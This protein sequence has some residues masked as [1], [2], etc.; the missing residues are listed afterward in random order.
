MSGAAASSSGRLPGECGHSRSISPLFIVRLTITAICSLYWNCLPSPSHR[1]TDHPEHSACHCI[2][3]TPSPLH[4][5]A[6][7]CRPPRCQPF[8][9]LL[10]WDTPDYSRSDDTWSINISLRHLSQA[11]LPTCLWCRHPGHL[12]QN[13]SLTTTL[14]GK[15]TKIFHLLKE[16]S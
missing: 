3:Q 11:L 8:P 1:R 5:L 7:C 4:P 14:M 10:Q 6:V 9:A 2:L 12:V 13:V 15:R 16:S